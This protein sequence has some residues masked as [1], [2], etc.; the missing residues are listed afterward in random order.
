ML[1]KVI[2]QFET[3]FGAPKMWWVAF[4]RIETRSGKEG[5]GRAVCVR[6]TKHE[7]IEATQDFARPLILEEVK[8][9]TSE[10]KDL[11]TQ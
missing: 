5:K 9:L 11:V 7:L 10:M 2:D 6:K 4:N 8:E 1:D 3:L